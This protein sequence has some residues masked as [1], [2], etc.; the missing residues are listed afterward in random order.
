MTS[1]ALHS[2]FLGWHHLHFPLQGSGNGNL[3]RTPPWPVAVV[4]RLQI[5]HSRRIPMCLSWLKSA[6]AEVFQL[7]VGEPLFRDPGETSNPFEWFH[8]TILE[9]KWPMRFV[10]VSDF[11]TPQSHISWECDDRMPRGLLVLFVCSF[12]KKGLNQV[13]RL[14]EKLDR[15]VPQTGPKLH[16]NHLGFYVNLG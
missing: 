1:P 6:L 9:P 5:N 8:E 3:P 12:G 13:N 7:Q 2:T 14:G 10:S 11:R 4:A 16:W 15:I